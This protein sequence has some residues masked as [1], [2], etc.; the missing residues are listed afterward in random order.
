MATTNS[1]AMSP[2]GTTNLHDRCKIPFS[3][4]SFGAQLGAGAFGSVFEGV[5]KGEAVA[6]K[7][8]SLRSLG[9]ME[10]KYIFGELAT[11]AAVSHPHLLKFFGA[12]EGG[13][14]E[15]FIVTELMGG[16][17]LSALLAPP[18][19]PLPWA[20][21]VAL[22]RQAAEGLAHLHAA[23]LLHRDVKTDNLLLAADSWR[24]VVA[25]YGFAK[26]VSDLRGGAKQAMT[27]L[28]TETF[29]AP[30]VQFGEAYG[31]GADI[32][33]LGCVFAHVLTGRE[34]GVG[35]FLERTPRNKFAADVEQL[36]AAVS[37]DAPPSL[38]ECTCQCLSSEP[39]ARPSAD[40]VVEWLR[41]L[42]A[43]L[44]IA[45]AAFPPPAALRAEVRF[46]RASAV[47][48]G[49]GGDP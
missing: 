38:V 34:P 46:A 11:L 3:D 44:P 31:E 15:L 43:E 4:L 48:D 9:G 10:T 28:G 23:E 40:V 21:R 27:I 5:L 12:A 2:G 22:C 26:H 1:G 16:G 8:V 32:F 7:S 33:S 30:E 14:K 36:R 29:M 17:P 20:L 25:D 18:A 47:A 13:N 19:P 42:A 45:G 41:D 49:G 35:G 39:E 6:I 37:P 24:L